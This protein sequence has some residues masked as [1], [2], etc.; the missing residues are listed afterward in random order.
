MGSTAAAFFIDEMY[1][2]DDTSAQTMLPT[3]APFPCCS[4]RCPSPTRKLLLLVQSHLIHYPE[5]RLLFATRFERTR[6]RNVSVVFVEY[7]VRS[8]A[9]TFLLST[10]RRH[11]ATT[12]TTVATQRAAAVD[13]GVQPPHRDAGKR[14]RREAAMFAKRPP[15][16]PAPVSTPDLRRTSELAASLDEGDWKVFRKR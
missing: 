12:L 5:T 10:F 1:E 3:V 15:L 7:E 13:T 6:I 9:K 11:S 14:R 16:P 4:S 2:R 8:A